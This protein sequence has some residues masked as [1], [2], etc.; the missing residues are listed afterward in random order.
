MTGLKATSDP[1]KPKEVYHLGAQSHVRVSC[2]IRE[3]MADVTGVGAIRIL[4]AIRE[5][6]VKTRFYRASRGAFAA[7]QQVR[8]LRQKYHVP[9]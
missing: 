9:E 1:D 7:P 2:D 8:V 6:G 3:Y 5:V 4:E